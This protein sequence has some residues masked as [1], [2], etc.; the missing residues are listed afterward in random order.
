[1][2]INPTHLWEMTWY[3]FNA[4]ATAYRERK[5]HDYDVMRHLASLLLAPHVDKKHRKS[6]IPTRLF[7]LPS[8]KPEVQQTKLSEEEA[9]QIIANMTRRLINTKE[10]N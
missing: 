6:I 7:P 3:E 5:L 1:M 8:D 10:V 9:A 4:V 2:G